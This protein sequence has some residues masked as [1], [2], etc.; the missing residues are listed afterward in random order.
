[1]ARGSMRG[2]VNSVVPLREGDSAVS[3]GARSGV[4]PFASSTPT[5][6]GA[7]H[8][9]SFSV[10]Q[11]DK[12]LAAALGTGDLMRRASMDARQSSA[13]ANKPHF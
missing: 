8:R 4:N 11:T 2:S 1:M 13:A 5:A 10:A 9:V 7:N 3:M 12:L 6:F